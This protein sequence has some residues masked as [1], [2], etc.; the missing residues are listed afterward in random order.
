MMRKIQF[1]FA[2][3]VS[4]APTSGPIE[5][6]SEETPAQMPIAVPRWRAGKVAVMI[7]FV[8]GLGVDLQWNRNAR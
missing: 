3:S 5:S 6:A 7:E 8:A 4:S 2:C 1:Q